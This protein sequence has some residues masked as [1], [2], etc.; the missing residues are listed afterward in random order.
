MSRS[1]SGVGFEPGLGSIG[2]AAARNH[3]P[4]S[5]VDPA[6]RSP[7]PPTSIRDSF[8]VDEARAALVER[9]RQA[10]IDNGGN[11]SEFLPPNLNAAPG[12]PSQ[13]GNHVVP[14]YDYAAA[15][16]GISTLGL[17]NN[18]GTTTPYILNTTSL[19]GTFSA[20]TDPLGLK[21]LSPYY[22]SLQSYGD[23]LNSVLN[24]TTVYGKAAYDYWLQNVITYSDSTHTL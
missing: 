2:S 22:G 15:P 21:V 3:P 17:E 18:T 20:G 14:L 12:P 9:A 1:S 23:Q 8:G 16:L 7:A 11:L 4:P 24:N 6:H 10:I 19:E 5:V 13:T